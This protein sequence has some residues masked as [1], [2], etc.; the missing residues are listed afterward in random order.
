MIL[1]EKITALRKQMGWSQ[2]E[3]A[4]QLSISRQ[5]VSKWELGASI[6][7]LEKIIRMSELFGVS[8]DYLLKDDEETA[9]YT[10][11]VDHTEEKTVSAEEADR[12]MRIKK[13]HSGK[14]AGAVSLFILS[15]VCLI[16]LAGFAESGIGRLSENAAGGL[17]MLILLLMVAAGVGICIWCGSETEEFEY[18][19][20]DF[21][22]LGYGV[23]GIVEKNRQNFRKTHK[24]GLTVGVSLCIVAVLPLLIASMFEADD[25]VLI[26]C[27]SFL[28][29]IIAAAA[30]L[31]V[32]NGEIMESYNI[33]LGREEYTDQN[34]ELR[35]RMGWFPGV[36]W[37]V[38]TA[39]FLTGFFWLGVLEGRTIGWYWAIAGV[40]YAPMLQ[41]VKLIAGKTK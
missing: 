39:G 32:R 4:E 27:V 33:L 22:S 12:F 19:K 10:G 30:A 17:G 24:I 7:D 23:K 34:K 11:Q 31:M 26:T 5:S 3:L 1:S 9:V 40:L 35:R 38:A 13:E 8:T 28:L 18:L 14:I 36:Y 21:F 29:C 6:P 20:H 2:E 37:G 25:L 41:I 16:Q 15:P